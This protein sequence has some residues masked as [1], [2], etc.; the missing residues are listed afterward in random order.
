MAQIGSLNIHIHFTFFSSACV[1]RCVKREKRTWKGAF[2]S[3]NF[4][5]FRIGEQLTS[6]ISST[7]RACICGVFAA[8]VASTLASTTTA[9]TY[10]IQDFHFTFKRFELEKFLKEKG[11]ELDEY[12]HVI[13]GA[14][15]NLIKPLPL[16][17]KTRGR[18][19]WH[20]ISPCED[21]P[22]WN[23]NGYLC[24]EFAKY[25]LCGGQEAANFKDARRS[26]LD[27]CC[28]CG[29]GQPA[30]TS[31]TPTPPLTTGKDPDFKAIEDQVLSA[32]TNGVE[33]VI[34]IEKANIKWENEIPIL[35]GQKIHLVGRIPFR[36]EKPIL[37]AEK[38]TRHI[39]V[40][41]GGTFSAENLVFYHGFAYDKGDFSTVGMGGSVFSRGVIPFIRNCTFRENKATS[42]GGAIMVSNPKSRIDE[43]SDCTFER[44]WADSEGGALAV[45]LATIINGIIISGTDFI[46]NTLTTSMKQAPFSIGGA[47]SCKDVTGGRILI[48]NSKFR[49]MW[50]R[51]VE[52]SISKHFKT[53]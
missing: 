4:A 21:I 49:K 16:N 30:G 48:S 1:S 35:S 14:F 2:S 51:Q 50:Q 31:T 18:K 26:P 17:N 7:M 37:D 22:G 47:I 43:V 25:E 13:L 46:E 52:L 44:N 33:V 11:G 12:A 40:L 28:A 23:Y 36:D 10:E 39:F 6:Y 20:S 41:E 45:T 34:Y 8:V 27:A 32:P 29:G 3:N 15:D 38:K 24:A 19:L 9:S 53:V 42:A 5:N